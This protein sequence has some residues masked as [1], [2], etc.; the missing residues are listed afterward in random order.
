MQQPERSNVKKLNDVLLRTAA[1]PQPGSP[2][3]HSPIAESG[4]DPETAS[5]ASKKVA[6][7]A[8]VPHREPAVSVQNSTNPSSNQD[9]LADRAIG[10]IRSALENGSA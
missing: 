7:E 9:E 6:D 3:D 2:L 10:M 5:D 1:V 4:G 8:P